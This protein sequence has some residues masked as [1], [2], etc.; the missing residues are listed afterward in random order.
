MLIYDMLS[1]YEKLLARNGFIK[2]AS[3]CMLVEVSGCSMYKAVVSARFVMTQE[4]PFKILN[5]FEKKKGKKQQHK[6]DI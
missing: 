6:H 4:R 3:M 1:Q 2:Y 5:R